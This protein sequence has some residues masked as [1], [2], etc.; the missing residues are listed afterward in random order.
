MTPESQAEVGNTALY[1]L[2]QVTHPEFG[3][4]PSPEGNRFN[5]YFTR[6][7]MRSGMVVS[8]R[9]DLESARLII[10]AIIKSQEVA[11]SHIGVKTDPETGERKDLL[12]HEV[13]S[14]NSPQD[15]LIELEKDHPV[16]VNSDGIREMVTWFADDVNSLFR[17]NVASTGKAL[18][19]LEGIDSQREYY[20]QRWP[21]VLRTLRH[22]IEVGD[23]DGD[24]LIESMPKGRNG[25]FINPTWKDSGD[26]YLT[27]DGRLPE[28]PY[29]YLTNNSDF[30]LSLLKTAEIARTLGYND[31]AADLE[32]R[33]QRNQ[34]LLHE[35]FWMEEHQ[36]MAPLI[37]GDGR[38][39]QFIGDDVVF[40]LYGKIFYLKEGRIIIKR[41]KK[42][43]MF[44][45]WGIRTR[46][47]LSKQFL[48][49][50]YQR[51]AVW[52]YITNMAAEGAENYGDY[53]FAEELDNS[54]TALEQEE[55]F[56]EL[57]TIYK[58]G[59]TKKT[60]KENGVPVACKP[61]AWTAATS[62]ARRMAH[63]PYVTAPL[64]TRN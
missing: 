32:N 29:K 21:V 64:A 20:L 44:T 1:N 3:I 60:Y 62:H 10:P 9:L 13:H 5:N 25:F 47:S 27:E 11:I 39:V 59:T 22:D 24:G 52:D 56:P 26:A 49:S 55:G 53:S 35:I 58:N 37:E 33:F 61:M 30:M 46:S 14:K 8:E 57:A 17:S 16:K 48:R 54:S 45:N 43:D 23:I 41:L 18:A 63:T 7:A 12:P 2:L 4:V 15:R 28:P 19:R 31:I 40:G 42:R 38:Q 51:G 36:F 6:D 34:K 50:A